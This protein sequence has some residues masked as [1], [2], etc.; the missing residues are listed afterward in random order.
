MPMYDENGKMNISLTDYENRT[1]T[2][3]RYGKHLIRT[4][5]I[6]QSAEINEIQDTA[7]RLHTIRKKQRLPLRPHLQYI[8]FKNSVNAFG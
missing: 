3:K 8:I 2:R 4:G 6:I 5:Q 1:D 7:H